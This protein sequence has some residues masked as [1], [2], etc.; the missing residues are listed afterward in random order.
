MFVCLRSFYIFLNEKVLENGNK[1]LAG[2]MK[3]R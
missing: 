3:E 2:K 1:N